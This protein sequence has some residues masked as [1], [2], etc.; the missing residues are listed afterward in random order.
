MESSARTGGSDATKTLEYASNASFALGCAHL[1][2]AN[3]RAFVSFVFSP[4][5]FF[6]GDEIDGYA[7]ANRSS[8]GNARPSTRGAGIGGALSGNADAK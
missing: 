1:P 3:P 6:P 7:S 8:T 4:A 2:R 5:R